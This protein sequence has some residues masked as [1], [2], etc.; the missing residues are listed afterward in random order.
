MQVS[1]QLHAS[2]TLD[3]CKET[4]VSIGY[5]AELSPEFVWRLRR[6]EKYFATVGNR[7]TAVQVVARLYAD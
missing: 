1:G 2:A 3:R 5:E 4:P 7:T 6:G